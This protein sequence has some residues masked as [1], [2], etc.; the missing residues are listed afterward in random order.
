MA[1]KTFENLGHQRICFPNLFE[2]YQSWVEER[3]R[4]AKIIIE[5]ERLKIKIIDGTNLPIIGSRNRQLGEIDEWITRCGA[6]DSKLIPLLTTAYKRKKT[7]LQKSGMFA[8]AL[9]T[10]LEK[11]HSFSAILAPNDDIAEGIY[12]WIQYKQKSIQEEIS[13]L[14]FDNN[15][16][17]CHIPISTVDFGMKFTGY[18]AAQIFLKQ[19]NIPLLSNKVIRPNCHIVHRG[20]LAPVKKPHDLR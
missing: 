8:L 14:S 15:Y 4:K 20:S 12:R 11:N 18:A 5:K 16:K 1:L 17:Y 9:M 3:L 10:V 7:I 13:V 19:V 6:F 2:E